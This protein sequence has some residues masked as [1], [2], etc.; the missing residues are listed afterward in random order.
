LNGGK[1]EKRLGQ[2]DG[3]H[4]ELLGRPG[5]LDAVK[6]PRGKDVRELIF[7]TFFERCPDQAKVLIAELKHFFSLVQ[8]KIGKDADGVPHVKK[9]VR[10]Q[11]E[12]LDKQ[13]AAIKKELMEKHQELKEGL[14]LIADP[15]D[16]F[17]I[18]IPPEFERSNVI[19]SALTSSLHGKI[20]R[21]SSSKPC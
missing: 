16:K 6:D 4:I 2:A 17:V 18:E 13:L 9:S 14:K 20:L 15:A 19:G 7:K 1:N 10:I 5:G 12:D 8:R 11:I 3:F 21:C